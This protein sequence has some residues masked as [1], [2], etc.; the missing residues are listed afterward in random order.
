MRGGPQVIPRPEKFRLG[1]KAPW[2]RAD[3]TIPERISCNEIKRI[4]S[5]TKLNKIPATYQEAWLGTSLT[6]RQRVA[7]EK[8]LNSAKPTSSV[9]VPL[10]DDVNGN[11]HTV[12]TRRSQMVKSHTGEVSFPGGKVET[13]ESIDQAA[14]RETFEE[15]GILPENVTLIG[16]LEAMPTVASGSWI[17]PLVGLLN[18]DSF[19]DARPE[20]AI[21]PGE[22]ER[23]FD[24]A[25]TDLM[26]AGVYREEIWEFPGFGEGP[27]GF[28]EV[29]G[30]TIWGATARIIRNF[31]EV[32]IGTHKVAQSSTR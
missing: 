27:V 30:D 23:V 15:V 16:H 7:A 17:V 13:D 21:N 28:F 24:I 18:P 4:L 12:L 10:F 25:L 6:P 32:I 22:V 11:A 2:E 1:E 20:Y 9:L 31:L 8:A 26:V 14:L 19:V 3:I 5:K 29:E